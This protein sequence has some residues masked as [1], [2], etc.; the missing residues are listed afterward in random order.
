[1]NLLASSLTLAELEQL[2]S[3][4]DP[5]VVLAP[6]RILRRVI[7]KHCG[8]G[9]PGLQVPHRKTFVLG[10]E[11]LL[12]I[13]GR[14]ELGLSPERIL[15]EVIILLPQPAASKLATALPRAD[16]LRKCWRLLFHAHVHLALQQRRRDGLLNDEAVRERIRRIGFTEF[17]EAKAVLRQENFLLPPHATRGDFI[18]L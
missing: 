11:D 12:A 14:H 16:V 10:R 17:G 7:K 13:A 2:L 3:A 6:P 8:I 5:G 15:P 1:M 4:A 18:G 9:G